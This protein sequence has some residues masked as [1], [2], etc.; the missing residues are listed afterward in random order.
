MRGGAGL[1]RGAI[2]EYQ[3]TFLLSYRDPRSPSGS[4]YNF[5]P[6]AL[7]H[8]NEGVVAI[9]SH[10]RV[11]RERKDRRDRLSEAMALGTR[12]HAKKTSGR[13]YRV[14]M[15]VWRRTSITRGVF[16]PRRARGWRPSRATGSQLRVVSACRHEGGV[17]M[18]RCGDRWLK[19]DGR[20]CR[21]ER[22]SNLI[23]KFR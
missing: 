23:W 13:A 20:V 4:V 16:R 21:H 14:T 22:L 1:P 15:T 7:S 8:R 12:F 10:T 18:T 3:V 17:C 19:L 9:R 11:P 6:D 5:V 2:L